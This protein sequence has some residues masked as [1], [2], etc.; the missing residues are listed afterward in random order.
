MKVTV[1]VL[2]NDSLYLADDSVV[3]ESEVWAEGGNTDP[4]FKGANYPMMARKGNGSAFMEPATW[5]ND[6]FDLVGVWECE[7]GE[8]T[9]EEINEIL[10]DMWITYGNSYEG[11]RPEGYTGRSLSIGDVVLVSETAHAVR[12]LGWEAIS[13]INAENIREARV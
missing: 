12:S 6:L 8:G 9:Q 7:V 3:R 2:T 10:V 13:G 4:R 11:T 5:A 1:K